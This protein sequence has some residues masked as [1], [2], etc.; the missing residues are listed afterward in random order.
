[1]RRALKRDDNFCSIPCIAVLPL[2]LVF[3]EGVHVPSPVQTPS[4]TAQEDNVYFR[5][6]QKCLTGN[7]NEN[8]FSRESIWKMYKQ[9]EEMK[10]TKL[11]CLKMFQRH[12]LS[13]KGENKKEGK[14]KKNK[15][16]SHRAAATGSF[17]IAAA[18]DSA[19]EV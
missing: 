4:S 13:C 18:A 6:E 11:Q 12:N 17:F 5:K 15:S 1:M 14:K 9:E 3:R 16:L 7:N 19:L 8:N 10:R 2:D